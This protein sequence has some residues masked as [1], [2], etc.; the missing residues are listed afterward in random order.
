LLSLPADGKRRH[1]ENTIHDKY[2]Y[3]L[4]SFR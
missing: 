2:K 3:R 4:Q 1:E